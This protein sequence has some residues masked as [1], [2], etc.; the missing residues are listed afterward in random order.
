[1]VSGKKWMYGAAGAMAATV[2]IVLLLQRETDAGFVLSITENGD[3]LYR[4]T[5][6]LTP[7][8]PGEV[9]TA[10]D[11]GELLELLELKVVTPGAAVS[12][13]AESLSWRDDHNREIHIGTKLC[14]D[15]VRCVDQVRVHPDAARRLDNIASAF[16]NA[17][18]VTPEDYKTWPFT[19]E[20]AVLRC[21]PPK[22]LTLISGDGVY[23]LNTPARSPQSQDIA[24]VLKDHPLRA[25]EKLSYGPV[26][27]DAIALCETVATSTGPD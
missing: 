4:F 9:E 21:L 16:D 13:T 14:P 1:M 10:G 27:F 6:V 11:F 22:R 15:G 5:G 20:R 17:R 23:A 24:G 7:S 18:L 25:G 12:G 26:F 2:A 8:L 19:V 3:E